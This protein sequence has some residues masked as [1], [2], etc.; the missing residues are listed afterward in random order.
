MDVVVVASTDLSTVVCPFERSS[1]DNL[2]DN[3]QRKLL[4]L[5]I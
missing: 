2:P 5:R 1:S 3:F 4:S